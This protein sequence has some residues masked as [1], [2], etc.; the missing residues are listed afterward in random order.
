[1][2][3]D[4]GSPVVD[5]A[6]GL[7]FVFFLLS[8]IVSAGT[9]AISWMVSRR[10]NDLERGVRGLLRDDT[11]ARA[12]LDHPLVS[13]DFKFSNKPR[14]SY[15]SARSFSLALIDTVAPLGDGEPGSR[16]LIAALRTNVGELEPC[17]P[18]RRELSA[19]LDAAGDN[20][21][22]F[23]ASVETW[24]NS[25]MD[26][27]SGLYRRWAQVIGCVIAL[28]V[29]VALNADALRI[30]DRLANDQAVRASVVNAANAAVVAEA[31][32]S[33]ASAGATSN[34]SSSNTVGQGAKQ[35]KKQAAAS[36]AA[37]ASNSGQSKSNSSSAGAAGN[38]TSS[39]G[40]N[41]IVAGKQIDKATD[42]L[43]ALNLPIGWNDAN[44]FKLT[45][46][47]GWLLTFIAISLGAP[48]WFDTLSRLAHLRTTGKKP[49]S[50][51]AEAKEN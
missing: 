28:V 41:P 17:S 18:L 33:T 11:K 48:F 42:Q 7:A 32:G 45:T 31:T 10:A 27:V 3:V 30:A 49:S 9:E 4:V 25:G 39:Q 5:V 51:P 37:G 13:V 6:I 36:G 12:V 22:E 35:G 14:P 1:M 24:F 34:Q 46:V 43:H 38:T 26:R 16:D 8:L 20:I 40:I 50:E 19:L 29:T 47:P 2:S 44:S 23:R 15:I 21:N